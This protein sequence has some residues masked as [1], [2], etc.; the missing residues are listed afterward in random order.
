MR[1]NGLPTGRDFIFIPKEIDQLGN[2]GG[3]LFYIVDINTLL[4]TNPQTVYLFKNRKL[5]IVQNDEKENCYLTNGKD[6]VFLKVNFE[7]HKMNWYKRIVKTGIM[8]LIVYQAVINSVT[9][10]VISINITADVTEIYPRLWENDG[11]TVRVPPEK[12]MPI[13]ILPDVKIKATKTYFLG[14]VDRQM[15]DDIF[16]KL[17]AQKRM[18]FISQPTFHGYPVFVVWRTIRKKRKRRVVI[19][20][21]GFNKITVTDFYLMPL[22]SEIIFTITGCQYISVFDATGF[23]YQ[24]LVRVIDR[25]KFT[26]VSHRSQK[27]FNVI[28]M[29]F[30]ISPPYV[31]KNRCYSA[32]IST[33][34]P[35]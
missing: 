22:Q 15:V 12:W 16:D 10:F 4:N 11:S 3:I 6:T 7:N 21:R 8:I 35:R 25:H 27:Q 18:E 1:G 32:F 19:N 5:N 34:R 33:I 20:I 28:I 2:D 9:E 17:H 14:P 26:V 29:G 23:F 13:D 31:K 24:W 30:K